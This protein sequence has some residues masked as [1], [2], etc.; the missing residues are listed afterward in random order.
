MLRKR[1]DTSLEHSDALEEQEQ[2]A[3]IENYKKED[4]WLTIMIKVALAGL[5]LSLSS[6]ILISF[7][8]RIDIIAVA[9]FLCIANVYILYSKRSV[10][11][12][13]PFLIMLCLVSV[14][15]TL[16]LSSLSTTYHNILI[17]TVI[18][19]APTAITASNLLSIRF[20][21]YDAEES[22]R[23]LEGLKYRYKGA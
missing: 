1:V 6:L 21:L 10:E 22:I 7:N 5:F 8:D 13:D 16:Y 2:D 11:L 19:L 4:Q 14:G 9:A 17:E 12:N 23:A 3:L 20:W 18:F 15:L